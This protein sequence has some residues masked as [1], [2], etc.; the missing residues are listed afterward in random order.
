M[1]QEI[2]LVLE[3]ISDKFMML[4]FL[5]TF[6]LCLMLKYNL[7]FKN[8]LLYLEHLSVLLAQLM[9][10]YIEIAL[11]ENSGPYLT[12]QVVQLIAE[13]RSSN[14]GVVLVGCKFFNVRHAVWLC[15]IILPRNARNAR[16]TRI[17]LWNWIFLN[18]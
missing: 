5:A 7:K 6:V 2:L 1:V 12:H 8:W 15:N 11:V 13:C 9:P 10:A 16:M 18:I 3:Y 17:S 4:I 14:Q